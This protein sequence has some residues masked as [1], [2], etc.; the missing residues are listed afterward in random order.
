MC[1]CV[2]G[3]DPNVPT[4]IIKSAW[5]RPKSN[6]KI[7]QKLNTKTTFNNNP[8]LGQFQLCQNPLK[9][10]FVCSCIYVRIK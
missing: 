5:L 10:Y 9:L 6:T 2:C 8:K 1:V 3:P 4:F 7:M